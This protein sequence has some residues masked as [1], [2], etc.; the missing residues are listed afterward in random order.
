M[1]RDEIGKFREAEGTSVRRMR[2][3]IEE[4]DKERRG[5]ERGGD[6]ERKD[7][8]FKRVE[9]G[10]NLKREEIERDGKE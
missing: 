8:N 9:E 5:S 4:T 7:S 6:R 1:S 2:G 10:R 3:E